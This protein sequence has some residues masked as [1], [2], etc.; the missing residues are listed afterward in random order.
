VT[1]ENEDETPKGKGRPLAAR[2][3]LVTKTASDEI[4]ESSVDA[5]VDI[6]DSDGNDVDTAAASPV[7]V[8]A[9]TINI[10]STRTREIEKEIAGHNATHDKAIAQEPK[11]T[12]PVLPL[13]K[14]QVRSVDLFIRPFFT[15][16]C[17]SH[18]LGCNHAETYQLL[19]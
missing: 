8:P 16:Y 2:R 6:K 7:T 14:K 15:Y 1:A 10:T 18:Y 13:V 4:K 5:A 3:S 12:S 9:A 11:E 19:M 17:H